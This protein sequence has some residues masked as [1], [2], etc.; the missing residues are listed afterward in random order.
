MR[1]ATAVVSAF[2]VVV[3]SVSSSGCALARRGQAAATTPGVA[4]HLRTPS[5]WCFHSA[6]GI[7]VYAPREA[8]CPRPVAFSSDAGAVLRHAGLQDDALIGVHVVYVRGAIECNGVQTFGCTDVNRRVSVVSLDTPWPRRLT[9]HEL[10]HQ[11]VKARGMP[12][13][14]QD[15]RDPWWRSTAVSV[16]RR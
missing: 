15:H 6:Q 13:R 8:D 2:V 3:A 10:G 5:E 14:H 4:E 9:Q 7:D 11:A 16:R 1:V 12:E